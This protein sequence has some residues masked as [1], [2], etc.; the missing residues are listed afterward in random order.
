MEELVG[1]GPLQENNSKL[2]FQCQYCTLIFKTKFFFH[3]HMLSTHRL[4]LKLKNES[5]YVNTSEKS[6]IFKC[7]QCQYET[8]IDSLFYNHVLSHKEIQNPDSSSESI[9][10]KHKSLLRHKNEG[11]MLKCHL[12]RFESFSRGHFENHSKK[13][14]SIGNAAKKI[15]KCHK[16]EYEAEGHFLFHKHVLSHQ[17]K[18]KS[19][20]TSTLHKFS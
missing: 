19:S 5:R 10:S 8:Q 3:E 20:K 14:M 17:K 9:I 15:H 6:N 13:H 2:F 7:Q 4:D 11:E 16:C 12:C 18:E 1:Y